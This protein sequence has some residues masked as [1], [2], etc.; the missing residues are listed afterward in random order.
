MKEFAQNLPDHETNGWT[1]LQSTPA[2]RMNYTD[3]AS[4]ELPQERPLSHR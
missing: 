2:R 3:I 4:Y 1:P